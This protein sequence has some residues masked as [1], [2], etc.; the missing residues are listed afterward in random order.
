[1]VYIYIIYIISELQVRIGHKDLGVISMEVRRMDH[2]REW[3]VEEKPSL[4]GILGGHL[5]RERDIIRRLRQKRETK[6]LRNKLGWQDAMEVKQTQLQEERRN[7]HR[8]VKENE[9]VF[10]FGSKGVR[11]EARLQDIKDTKTGGFAHLFGEKEKKGKTRNIR[12]KITRKAIGTKEVFVFKIKT[13]DHL[14]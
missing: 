2:F 10:R 7:Y 6:R 3:S 13:Y 12:N 14:K 11:K 1:M 9:R 8:R 4:V 5:Y